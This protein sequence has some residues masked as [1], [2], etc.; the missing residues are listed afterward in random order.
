M[1][2]YRDCSG[3]AQPLAFTSDEFTHLRVYGVGCSQH[4][5]TAYMPVVRG[6]NAHHVTQ[7]R[8]TSALPRWDTQDFNLA[9]LACQQG[10]PWERIPYPCP[11]D[12]D[13]RGA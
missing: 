1:H 11:I 7:T 12:Y 8:V 5:S 2:A 4:V 9:L 13:A 10:G 6:A 3:A